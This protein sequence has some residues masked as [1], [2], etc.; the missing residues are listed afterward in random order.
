MEN[1][2]ILLKELKEVAKDVGVLDKSTKLRCVPAAPVND[3]AAAQQPPGR[4]RPARA[5]RDGSL[6]GEP[7]SRT[8]LALRRCGACATQ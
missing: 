8:R 1:A 6:A 7:L 3:P 4:A 5:R 2:K